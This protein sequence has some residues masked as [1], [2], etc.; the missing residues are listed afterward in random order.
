MVRATLIAI[1]AL[2]VNPGAGLLVMQS[3]MQQ[4]HSLLQ[5]AALPQLKRGKAAP[6]SDQQGLAAAQRG[7]A[8][9]LRE[10][11]PWGEPVSDEDLAMMQQSART[12][13]F[14]TAKGLQEEPIMIT[15][16]TANMMKYGV[17]VFFFI[18]G[19]V[20][21]H[22]LLNSR[23]EPEKLIGHLNAVD[24]TVKEQTSSGEV[25][26]PQPDGGREEERA[27]PKTPDTATPAQ[28]AAEVNV[29]ANAKAAPAE[30]SQQKKA[31]APV[32]Q[33]A[34]PL[35]PD[36]QAAGGIADNA[37]ASGAEEA[38]PK[39]AKMGDQ[40]KSAA[41]ASSGRPTRRRQSEGGAQ[42]GFMAFAGRMAL[43]SCG[44]WSEARAA[45]DAAAR[46]DS[47]PQRAPAGR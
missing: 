14:G 25:R 47:A 4:A 6:T 33:E 8:I 43:M 44:R 23:A 40:E 27:G 45:R 3:P 35:K 37:K 1:L 20:S 18:L 19:M 39:P 12:G 34:A 5:I 21:I 41:P 13:H 29:G 28:G 36:A 10:L 26:P 46:R 30:V 2:A 38:P 16:Q 24:D 17:L 11:R 31:P 7:P 22:M 42:S 32:K 9:E 15:E